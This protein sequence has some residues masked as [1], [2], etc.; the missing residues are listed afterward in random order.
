MSS[1][2]LRRLAITCRP[3][4]S[5]YKHNRTFT[6]SSPLLTE[7]NNTTNAT[8]EPRTVTLIPGK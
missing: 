2:A 8:D 7:T 5:I 1:I 3:T 4:A 6:T